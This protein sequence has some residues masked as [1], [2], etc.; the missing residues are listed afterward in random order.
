MISW[1]RTRGVG[2]FLHGG[3]GAELHDLVRHVVDQQLDRD[4]AF[5]TDDD[6]W[7]LRAIGSQNILR[8]D[9]VRKDLVVPKVRDAG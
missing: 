6:D 1:A 2:A 7:V 3:Q 8:C 5:R 9:A 4:D